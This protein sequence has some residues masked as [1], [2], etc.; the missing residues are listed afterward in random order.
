MGFVA[1]VAVPLVG[2]LSILLWR[3]P[4]SC[5]FGYHARQHV[6]IYEDA[7]EISGMTGSQPRY[8]SAGLSTTLPRFLHRVFM[9]GA[10]I[11]A[12]LWIDMVS[13]KK[14]CCHIRTIRPACSLFMRWISKQADFANRGGSRLASVL[15]LHVRC[16]SSAART[17]CSGLGKL[18]WRCVCERGAGKARADQ[19]GDYGM[20]RS[21]AV[22]C[23]VRLWSGSAH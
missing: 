13:G 12:V 6:R 7:G 4:D 9:V 16:A 11:G 18:S 21:P 2:W 8:V 20:F 19:D 15:W 23:A 3:S 10:L 22:Q 17:D 5:G 1:V 14:S